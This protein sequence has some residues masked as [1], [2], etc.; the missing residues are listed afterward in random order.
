MATTVGPGDWFLEVGEVLMRFE[1][2]EN[3]IVRHVQ[4]LGKAADADLP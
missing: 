4:D 2:E 3:V 1:I